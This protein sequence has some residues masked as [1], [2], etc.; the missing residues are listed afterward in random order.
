MI[1]KFKLSY[2]YCSLFLGVW[3]LFI[4]AEEAT[5]AKYMHVSLATLKYL[6]VCNFLEILFC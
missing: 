4:N 1:H 2:F 5:K 6:I 3:L